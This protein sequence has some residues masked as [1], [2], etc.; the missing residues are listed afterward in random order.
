MFYNNF[1]YLKYFILEFLIFKIKF[2]VRII[3]K[4]SSFLMFI[5]NINTSRKYLLYLHTNLLIEMYLIV[6]ITFKYV[7]YLNISFCP[8]RF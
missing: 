6:V 3:L 1:E 5:S 2:F 4:V 7:S 8:V